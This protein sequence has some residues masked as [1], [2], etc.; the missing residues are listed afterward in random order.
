[1]GDDAY[2]AALL[3]IAREVERLASS[4]RPER[5]GL[6]RL[7]LEAARKY[8][9]DK[10][11]SNAELAALLSDKARRL[12]ATRPSRRLSGIVT[13][14]V[15]AMPYDCPPNARCIYCPGGS[16]QGTPKSYVQDSPAVVHA[17][18]LRY[19]PRAQVEERISVLERLGHPTSKVEVIIVGGTFLY[20]PPDYQMSFVKGIFEGLNGRSAD[21]LEDA[22]TAN[23]LSAHR[24]VGLSLETRPD[25]CGEHHVDLMLSY[26]V[27]RVEIGVQALDERT[28]LRVGRGHGLPEVSR[29]IRIAKDAGLKVGVHMMPCL[30]GRTLEEDLDDL[31]RLFEDE[32]Y[33]PDMLKIYPTLVLR[34]TPL[35]RMYERG[36]YEPCGEDEVVELLVRALTSMPPWARVMRVQREIPPYAVAA[37]PRMTGLRD[38]ALKEIAR[39]G[40]RCTEIRC[41]EVGRKGVDPSELRHFRL[42]RRDYAASGGTEAFLSM[43]DDE[44]RIAGFLR[45]R[46]PSPLAHRSEMSG[47]SIAVVRELRVYGSEVDVGDRDDSGWQHRGIGR[48]LMDEAERVAREEWNSEEVLVTSAV[49]TREYYRRLGYS[50]K[51]PY[52]A[53]RVQRTTP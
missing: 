14:T 39:R 10:I 2:R 20:Y 30:P 35:H 8:S 46:R 9:L 22:M 13:A 37:G 16:Q 6:E 25:F 53:K 1:L 36:L 44:G 7:K 21:S 19:D 11:P 38:L 29:A 12:V 51:G 47:G 41:R 28:L 4:G 40:L 32:S 48:M 43:E 33:R 23:E 26:G 18:R 31:S 24:C 50:R 5:E 34:G 17:S 49:G 45:L 27:T 15:A 42:V 52:M 3:E